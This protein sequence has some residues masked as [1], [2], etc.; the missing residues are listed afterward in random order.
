MCSHKFNHFVDTQD[1]NLAENK[2]VSP[3][4]KIY[5]LIRNTAEGTI[6]ICG[7]IWLRWNS[8]LYSSWTPQ[9][10]IVVIENYERRFY[11]LP[12]FLFFLFIG[13]KMSSLARCFQ[14]RVLCLSFLHSCTLLSRWLPLI[15]AADLKFF[16]TSDRPRSFLAI[17]KDKPRLGRSCFI[18]RSV[19]RGKSHS[20]FWIC[21][22]RR[23]KPT[24]LLK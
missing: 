5:S 17:D 14:S 3:Q 11:L 20:H 8:K 15:E 13:H 24:H 9:T 1:D 21:S 23:Q 2:Y 7:R 16:W 19:I 6:W 18:P 12:C 4:S 22:N 10:S